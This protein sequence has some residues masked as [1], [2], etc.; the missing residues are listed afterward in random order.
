M[1]GESWHKSFTVR[2]RKDPHGLTYNNHNTQQEKQFTRTQK[3]SVVSSPFLPLYKSWWGRESSPFFLNPTK[4]KTQTQLE[5]RRSMGSLVHVKEATIVTP[6][7]PTPSRVLSLS[8]LDSQLFLRFT[9]E[10]LLVYEGHPGLDQR[11]TV[12]RVKAALGKA[13][14]PYYP[15]A[16][17]VRAKP[18]GSGLEVVCR[19]QGVWFVEASSDHSVNEF[20]RAPRFVTQWR[21]FLS[22][23]VADV[24]K[25]APPLVVQLT[26]LKDGN[27]ALG[28]G[29]TH[30]LC[31][32]IG[33][34][35]FLNSFA[36]L[37]STSQT[38]FSEFKFKPKP[39]WD[40]HLLNPAPCKPSRNNNNNNN[41]SLS[42]PEFN[43]VPD[44]CGFQARFSNER[45]VPTSFIFNKTS[46]N[47]L[48]KVAF[49]TS[50]L[51]EANYTSFEVLSAHIWRSWGRALNL[52]S[53]QILKLLFSINVRERVKPSLP[54]GYYGNA[55]VLGCAQT[56]VKDLTEKGLGYATMLVKRAKERVD[57]EFVKSVVESVSQGR[58]SPDSVGVLILS[59][60]S[61]LG[62]EKVDFGMGRPVQVGPVCCDRYCLLLPV[63]NQ[64]DAVKAMVAVPTSAYPRYEH[65][66]RSFCS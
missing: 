22:F 51:S 66:V 59:Q 61:R 64:T 2:Q 38:K 63:F 3:P 37:A 20:G 26:W 56:S 41:H 29:I 54:S 16:G 39:V 28:V 35:E 60:W 52:P 48:K 32:G 49:S 31:D 47:E 30:C 34:A 8:A 42:H 5:R 13:L 18:D 11:A 19:A 15:F 36:E 50:R 21:K 40:R 10:Y 53:N 9:I 4:K 58:A 55:F 23:Q 44:L 25:G 43:R 33:S 62:L 57:G 27:A 12:A 1:P 24:L 65:L 7:E 46:L 6:C 17:R 14:V 45:L